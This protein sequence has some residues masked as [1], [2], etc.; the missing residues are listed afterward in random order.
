MFAAATVV[1]GGVLER[2]PRLRVALLEAGSAWGPYLFERLDEHWEKR[3]D[4]MPRIT[5]AAERV[6]RRRPASS[7]RARA[8]STC[9]TRSRGSA[10]NRS[11]TP[12]TTRTGTPSSPTRCGTS[13][14]V[15]T[16]TDAEKSAR[17]RRAT[18]GGSWMGPHDCGGR[19]SQSGARSSWSTSPTGSPRSRSTGPRRR[20]AINGA[21]GRRAGAHRRRPRRARRRRRD[22]PHRCRPGVLRRRRPEGAVARRERRAPRSPSSPTIPT[23]RTAATSSGSSRFRGPFPPHT[24]LLIGAING[25]AITGGFELALNCD[26]LDRVGARPLR[27]HARAR[28]RHARLGT[29]GAA[30]R[31]DRAAAGTRAQRHRQLPRRARRRS[32]GA[33]STTSS[34]TTSSSPFTRELALAAVQNDQAGVRRMLA[35]YDEIA[36]AVYDPGWEIEERRQPRV[37][38]RRPERRGDRQPPRRDRRARPRPARRHGGSS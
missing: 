15:T 8:S 24:K 10:R 1:C 30:R 29:H 38:R 19:M 32:P 3:P 31:D 13:R 16:S 28:R 11:S 37:A 27:R 9:R 35:T 26:L 14:T 2:F 25:P 4:E 20:N 22:D 5:K 21:L 17:A 12:P 36:A 33:S 18:P 23:T 7:S 6:P 34:R